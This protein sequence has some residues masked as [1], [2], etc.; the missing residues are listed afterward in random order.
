MSEVFRTPERRFAGL[1]GYDFEPNYLELSGDLDG[2]R[3]HYVEE[4][5][6]P[7]ILLLHGEPTWS[8][9]YRKMIPGLVAHGR[10]I[11]PDYIGFG[12]SDKPMDMGWYTYERHVDSIKQLLDA[13][14]LRDVTLVVHDWGGPIGLRVAVEDE[15]RF[16]RLVI[17]NTAVFRPRP[18]KPPNQA[19][20]QWR[21]FAER[22]PDL[23]IGFLL[24]GAT[25]N[26]LS[27]AVI[28]GYEAPYV[29]PAS[30]AGTAAFPLIVPLTVD[31]VGASEMAATSD[32]LTRWTKPVLVAFSDSDPLF[33]PRVG[34]ALSERIPG[35]RFAVVEG[36]SHFLQE[37]K[38]EEIADMVAEF[39]KTS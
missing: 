22:N 9:L 27:D 5:T 24:Q 18:G 20:L 4:G 38:G 26:D 14:D 2:L 32:A 35:A 19:F 3:M 7:P 21:D 17:L 23:P 13:L 11:A 8:F 31:D 6:G 12:R 15:E 30:K 1:E 39:I 37:D 34:E 36:A 10:V 33:S 16:S 25:V 29:S 28:A